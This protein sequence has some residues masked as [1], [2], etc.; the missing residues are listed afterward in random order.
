MQKTASATIPVELQSPVTRAVYRGELIEATRETFRVQVHEPFLVHRLSVGAS[1]KNLI[2]AREA[3]YEMVVTVQA[4]DGCEL[5]L[6]LMSP[7]RRAERRARKRYPLNL[8]VEVRFLPDSEEEAESN[9]LQ[10]MVRARALDIGRGGMRLLLE[11]P[12][13]V[14]QRLQLRFHLLNSDEPVCTKASVRHVRPLGNG[15]WSV[16]VAFEGMNR[17]DAHWLANLFP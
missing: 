14:G 8:P 4:I 15:Y 17:L 9:P 12:V 13:E 10:V 16:G 5:V 2:Q 7:P 6:K 1:L 3:P 11:Q